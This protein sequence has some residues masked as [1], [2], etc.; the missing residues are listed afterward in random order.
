MLKVWKDA[1]TSDSPD[2][3]RGALLQ[4]SLAKSSGVI[5]QLLIDSAAAG[6]AFYSANAISQAHPFGSAT[7]AVEYLVYV[8]VS[9]FLPCPCFPHAASPTTRPCL[10]S[11]LASR[12]PALAPSRPPA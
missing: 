10:P 4:R 5:A 1:G 11:G 6:V 12:L 7:I 8:L 3:L 2:K 9:S